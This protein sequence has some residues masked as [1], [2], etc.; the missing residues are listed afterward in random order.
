MGR[1][2]TWLDLVK[3][4]GSGYVRNVRFPKAMGRFGPPGAFFRGPLALL[5]TIWARLG[6]LLGVSRGVLEASRTV[7]QPSGA[8]LGQPLADSESRGPPEQPPGR[9][10]RPIYKRG[11]RPGPRG[12]DLRYMY[13]CR[14]GG[15]GGWP[16]RVAARP[17][18]R[19]MILST[20]SRCEVR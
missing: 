18:K 16:P 12:R 10:P 2:W 4:P 20:K 7:W 14:S 9:G 15:R 5:E 8:L 6:A 1:P 17:G 3:I 11:A 13:I 19:S